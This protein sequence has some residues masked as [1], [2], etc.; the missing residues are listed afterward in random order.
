MSDERALGGEIVRGL[1]DPRMLDAMEENAAYALADIVESVGGERY[2]GPDMTRYI[3]GIPIHFLNGVISARLPADRLD[4][5]IEETLEPFRARST[6]MVWI[7]SPGSSPDSLG[8]RL[9]AHGLTAGS[10]TPCMALDITALPPLAQLPSVTFDQV[11]NEASVEQFAKTAADGFGFGPEAVPIFQLITA[12]AC[13]PPDPHWVYHL[14]FLDGQ[15][16]ATSATFLHA[17]VAG[18]YTICTLPGARGRGIGGAITQL[19]LL[20]AAALGYRVSVLQATPMG[21]P[22]YRRLGFETRA[23]FHEYEWT[24]PQPTKSGAE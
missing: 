7:V 24:P 22:V 15:P 12:R 14:G 23:V 5:A 2:H 17:G 6:P 1:D 20:H 21:F 13:L 11:R 4:A 10:E 8:A 9:E 3:S 18:L 16:V 19:A